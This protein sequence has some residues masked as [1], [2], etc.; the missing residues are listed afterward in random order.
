MNT[1][2]NKTSELTESGQKQRD[3]LLQQLRA[4]VESRPAERSKSKKRIATSLLAVVVVALSIVSFT[5]I[6]NQFEFASSHT[7]V[8]PQPKRSAT[9]QLPDLET[10]NPLAMTAHRQPRITTT[11]AKN[12]QH[13]LDRYVVNNRDV[14]EPKNFLFDTM[15]DDQLPQ[16]LTKL[17]TGL[18]V[19][20]VNN[21]LV[22]FDLNEPSS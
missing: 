15:N 11:I 4:Q 9:N 13:V 22:V 17:K 21:Q 8:Q 19:V 2:T 18:S 16:S 1:K 14:S 3:K 10:A 5:N 7:P 20:R 6:Q 12:R